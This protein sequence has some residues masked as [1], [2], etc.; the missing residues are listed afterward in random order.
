MHALLLRRLVQIL[1]KENY[2]KSPKAP[3]FA[4]QWDI[5][6]NKEPG[7]HNMFVLLMIKRNY[8]LKVLFML[9]IYFTFKLTSSFPKLHTFITIN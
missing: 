1:E 2:C 8:L 5:L 3:F 6:K 9:F 7:I 4:N